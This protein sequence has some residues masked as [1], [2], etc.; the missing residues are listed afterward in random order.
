MITKK[1]LMARTIGLL[2]ITMLVVVIIILIFPVSILRASDSLFG[3]LGVGKSACGSISPGC[4][5]C[6]YVSCLEPGN[7]AFSNNWQGSDATIDGN[8]VRITFNEPLREGTVVPGLIGIY[9]RCGGSKPLRQ[10]DWQMSYRMAWDI[11]SYATISTGRDSIEIRG[12]DSKCYYLVQLD[13]AI[14]QSGRSL[15]DAHRMVTFKT[16]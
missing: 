7:V 5:N 2:I 3:L 1:G 8:S 12:F 11:G 14:S 6:F 9:E 10:E 15:I 13:N 16:G 4:D